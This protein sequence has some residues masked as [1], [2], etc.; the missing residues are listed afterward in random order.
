MV[1]LPIEALAHHLYNSI[2]GSELDSERL[3]LETFF[4]G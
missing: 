1:I 3:S 2:V 4:A